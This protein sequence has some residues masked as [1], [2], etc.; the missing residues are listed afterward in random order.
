[1]AVG[2]G[3]K[4][5]PHKLNWRL[6]LLYYSDF[7]SEECSIRH[8]SLFV[9]VVPTIKIVQTFGMFIVNLTVKNEM[10]N[11]GLPFLFSI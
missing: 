2:G 1:M 9:I 11:S 10:F 8:L 7:F 3:P 5:I 6:L 4:D